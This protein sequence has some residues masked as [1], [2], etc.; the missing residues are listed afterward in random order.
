MHS[1]IAF[2]TAETVAIANCISFG[3]TI[4]EAYELATGVSK[5]ILDQKSE[6]EVKKVQLPSRFRDKEHNARD[7]LFELSQWTTTLVDSS[8]LVRY[9]EG[10]LSVL[11]ASKQLAKLL[12]LV[13]SWKELR[14]KLGDTDKAKLQ[15]FAGIVAKG[16]FLDLPTARL[17]A[18]KAI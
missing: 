16:D 2:S 4:T 14:D 8:V 9:T 1:S 18:K 5:D 11:G 10:P 6:E 7:V 15:M 13:S 3:M 17:I 12:P